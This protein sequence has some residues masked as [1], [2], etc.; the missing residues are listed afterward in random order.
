[1]IDDKTIDNLAGLARLALAKEEKDKLAK[2]LESILGYVSELK[3]APDADHL[4]A[5]YFL[6]NVM[7]EDEVVNKPG[8]FT[9][10]IL[11]EMK[12]TDGQY[13]KVKKIL[14]NN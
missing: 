9:E 6:E 10:D 12:N 5:G 2:D 14:D 13:L 1:M 8:E 7:R 3:N 11:A 4:P